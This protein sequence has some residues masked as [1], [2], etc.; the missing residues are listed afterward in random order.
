MLVIGLTGGIG[1]GK[2][3]VAKLF[4]EKNIPII[5]TDV[6]AKELTEPGQPAYQEI[7]RHFGE[8][9]LQPD[10]TIHRIN[11]RHIIFTKPHE[12]KWLEQLL[13]PLIRSEMD[14]RIKHCQGPYCI[15]VIPLLTESAPNPLIQRIL[16]V[17]TSKDLQI[18][19]TQKRDNAS[20]DLI[21]M[22]LNSQTSRHTRLKQANDIIHNISDLSALTQQVIDLHQKYLLLANK[23]ARNV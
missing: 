13:H 20:L 6:I 2:S 3:T 4:A 22:I 7:V 12:R 11:L 23:K 5:D 21:S 15:V 19:R 16:V 18:T 17:D 10:K 9:I 8:M 1:S 14:R